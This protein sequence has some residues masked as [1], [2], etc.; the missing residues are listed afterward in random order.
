[1]STA[2]GS[3]NIINDGLVFYVD[4]AN[5]ESYIDGSNTWNDLTVNKNNGDLTNG[6]I[7]DISNAG[8]ISFDGSNDVVIVQDNPSINNLSRGTFSVSAWVYHFGGGPTGTRQT[9]VQK[10]Q[11]PP[12]VGEGGWILSTRLDLATVRGFILYPGRPL[13]LLTEAYP[14]DSTYGS[15][16]FVNKWRYITM[17]YDPLTRRTRIYF[18]GVEGIYV[19]I[20]IPP[21]DAGLEIGVMHI[22]SDGSFIV[23]FKGKLSNISIYNRIL[24]STEILQNYN[25]L[26]NRY[27]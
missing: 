1:M 17:T 20:F 25:A 4:A 7:F 13:S 16:Y 3:S 11:S 9:I 10:R 19:Q 26:K 14:V 18:N 15:S 22:G 6:P 21:V 12:G 27:R 8:A 24:S 23:P 5:T 2:Q